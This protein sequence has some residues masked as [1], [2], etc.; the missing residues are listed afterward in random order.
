M[1]SIKWSDK[2]VKAVPV[3][4]DYSLLVD[5]VSGNNFRYTLGSQAPIVRATALTGLS[6]VNSAI[7]ATDTILEAL[8]KAQGQIDN[9]VTESLWDVSDTSYLTPLMGNGYVGI[10]L[11][12]DA[13]DANVKISYESNG[14]YYNSSDASALHRFWQTLQAETQILL[15][16]TGVLTTAKGIQLTSASANARLG[17]DDG[18][19]RT[20]LADSAKSHIWSTGTIGSAA[21]NATLSGLGR[22]RVN[23]AYGPGLSEWAAGIFGTTTGED[24]VCLGW[25]DEVATIG[26]LNND[27]TAFQDLQ[28]VGTGKNLSLLFD[29]VYAP[30]VEVSGAL[31][32]TGA[33]TLLSTLG[34]TGAITATA[35]IL[36]NTI[37]E[38]TAANNII[39]TN[40]MNIRSDAL[41]TSPQ[42][43]I[44]G[45]TAT[46]KQLKISFDT[47]IN[48]TVFEA[49]NGAS[50]VPM[51]YNGLNHYFQ[52][53]GSTIPLTVSSTGIAVVG[54]AT[55]ST[56]LGVTGTSTLAAVNSTLHSAVSTSSWYGGV[57]GGTGGTNRVVSGN[58]N[59]VSSI[60]GHNSALNAWT[61]LYLQPGVT[62]PGV[63]I[64]LLPGSGQTAN[65]SLH[66]GG[67]TI[68]GADASPVADA[69]I[70]AGQMCIY[71][72]EGADTINF[73]VRKS[74]GSYFTKTI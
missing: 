6:L 37:G 8:G 47:S 52:I 40:K 19:I 67:S 71:L 57:F 38:R 66:S 26:A 30:A 16:T 20:N 51:Y 1:P 25:Y 12:N 64:C 42:L 21:N 39:A 68:I 65:A 53:N 28:I 44:Q 23:N 46:T 70:Y 36:T 69:G 74:D 58:I 10:K 32:A 56:T 45:A 9:L 29:Q 55:V 60:G 72:N 11:I 15:N 4:A 49:A 24:A 54:A 3:A 50:W 48:A 59:A 18:N 33:T 62:S 73:R 14:I 13:E 34:V 2:S 7:L 27:L 41:F 31:I 63:G 22:F 5:S 43:T 61:A 35:G 17:Y